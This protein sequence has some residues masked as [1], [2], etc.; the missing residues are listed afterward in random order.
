[1]LLSRYGVFRKASFSLVFCLAFSLAACSRSETAAGAT[2]LPEP[3]GEGNG[4]VTFLELGSVGCKPC[5][6]M[7]P[8]LDAVRE[9]Y[10]SQVDVVFHNVRKEPE[11]AMKW[12]VTLIPTQVFLDRE[13][14][15]YFRHE[16]FFPLE[17]VEKILKKGGLK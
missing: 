5:E 10:G 13:G 2:G 16:G 12:R 9:K 6:A 8:V 15:E 11:V 14:K 7:V 1:M 3:S 17:E 4:R